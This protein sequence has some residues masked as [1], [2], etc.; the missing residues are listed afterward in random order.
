MILSLSHSPQIVIVFLIFSHIPHRLW[1]CFSFSVTCPT[2]CDCVSQFQPHSPQIVIVFIILVTFPTD[3]DCVSQ[4]QPHSPQ[5][6]IVFLSFSHIPHRL[7]LCFSV[8][9]TFPTDKFHSAASPTLSFGREACPLSQML[10]CNISCIM[11]SKW[12]GFHV[13]L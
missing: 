12:P 13:T 2:H 6:V 8:L 10:F 5:I 4:F 9:V 1:S 3:C 11:T 7:W